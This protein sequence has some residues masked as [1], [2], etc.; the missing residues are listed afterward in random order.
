M[1]VRID[2][3]MNIPHSC[4]IYHHTTLIDFES[5]DIGGFSLLHTFLALYAVLRGNWNNI[6]MF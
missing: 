5:R 4:H 3:W 6:I 2:E 1:N